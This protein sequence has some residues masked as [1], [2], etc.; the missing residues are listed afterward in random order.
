MAGIEP[1]P[2]RL[3]A[4]ARGTQLAAFG[5]IEWSLLGGVALMWGS[6]YLLIDIG[7]DAL[8]PPVVTFGRLV[9]GL[10]TL[11]VLPSSWAPVAR[12]HWPRIA[13]LGIIWMAVP[14]SL[15]PVAQQ[16]VASSIAGALSATS[17]LFA[18]VIAWSVLSYAPR[19]TQIAGL[20]GGFAGV[21][22]IALGVRG[23]ITGTI[24]GV[25]LILIATLAYGVSLNLVI[26][27]QQRYGAIPV[28]MR[29]QVVA[30]VTV[31]PFA[32]AGIGRSSFEAPSLVAVVLL[33]VFGSAIAVAMMSTLLGRAGAARGSIAVYTIPAVALLLGVTIRGEVVS[34]AQVIGIALIVVGAYLTSRAEHGALLKRPH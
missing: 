5:L 11:A 4:S 20:V 22:F 31:A 9:L 34:A 23:E 32:A 29:A 27:L 14:W 13:I 2:P 18:A 21:A 19:W 25:A 8:A 28:L 6:A 30:S 16:W 7:L 15:F 3:R 1:V 24:L 10:A 33:G 12:A 17:S 26:P